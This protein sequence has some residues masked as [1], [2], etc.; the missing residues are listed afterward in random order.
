MREVRCYEHGDAEVVSEDGGRI[1]VR[2][3]GEDIYLTGW[4]D[5]PARGARLEAE[6]GTILVARW[7]G[8]LVQAGDER[9]SYIIIEVDEAAP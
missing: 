1:G 7:V 3:D 5:L 8:G 2:V 4:D 6:D 9:G